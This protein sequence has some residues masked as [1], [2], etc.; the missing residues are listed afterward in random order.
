MYRK[1]YIIII[2]YLIYF[3]LILLIGELSLRVFFP[4]RYHTL[5]DERNTIYSYHEKLGWFQKSNQQAL[6]KASQEFIV[7]TNNLGFRDKDHDPKEKDRILFLGDSFTWGY[8]VEEKNRFTNNLQQKL[9]NSHD[10][11][12]MGVSGYGTD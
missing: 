6:Y 4:N 3:I 9:L 2:S 11:L 1:Y 10:I 7:N 8:D 5:K 12:N